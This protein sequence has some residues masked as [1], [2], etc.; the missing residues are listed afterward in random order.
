MTVAV[1]TGATSGIGKELAERCVQH[2]MKAALADIEEPALTRIC[3]ELRDA[4]LSAVG[5]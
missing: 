5:R 4:H 1:V 3:S 2:G